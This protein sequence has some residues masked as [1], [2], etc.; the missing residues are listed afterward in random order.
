MK[1]VEKEWIKDYQEFLNG[2]RTAVPE[3]ISKKILTK[4]N[5]DLNPS[6]T[7]VFA[8][9][10]ITHAI[11]GTLSL[12]I[13]EQ[14]GVAPFRTGF[15]LSHYFMKFGHNVCLFLCGFLFVSL[16]VVMARFILRNE[17]FRVLGKN[18][19]F[20]IP[21]LSMVSLSIFWMIGAEI[22]LELSLL[23]LLGAMLGGLIPAIMMQRS[24]SK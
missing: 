11:T 22:F 10:F 3:E 5:S 16:S 13:C 21:I 20:Q 2:P 24:V 14:F 23:W 8:K 17:D 6:A 15:S 1:N 12:T 19:K 4:I 9:L 18:A 7:T